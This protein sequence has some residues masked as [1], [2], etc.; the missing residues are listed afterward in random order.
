[1]QYVKFCRWLPITTGLLLG[2]VL[3]T[4][5]G[6]SHSGST[7]VVKESNSKLA[8]LSLST[9]VMSPAFSDTVTT[10]A[11]TIYSR[12]ASLQV[13]PTTGSSKAAVKVNGVTV[14]S[15]SGTSVALADGTNT[16]TILV[17]AEDGTTTTTTLTVNR[18]PATTP[19]YVLDSCNG[20]VVTGAT[21][22]VADDTGQTLESGIA[23]GS[24]GTTTLGLDTTKKYFLYSQATGAAQ[25][26]AA[27]FDPNANTRADFY[28]HDLGMISYPASAPVV[29]ALSYSADGTT[30]TPVTGNAITDVLANIRFLRVSA[31][32]TAG[33]SP[34]AWSGFGM[35]INVDRAAWSWDYTPAINEVENSTPVTYNGQ[36]RYRSTYDFAVSFTNANAATTHYIDLVI[37]DVANNRTEQKIPVTVTDAVTNTGDYDLSSATPTVNLVQ[38]S[39][40]ALTRDIFVVPSLDGGD[41]SYMTTVSFFVNAGGSYRGI[42]GFDL[43]RSSDGTNFTKVKTVNYPSLVT[44]SA[45]SVNDLDP[46]LAPGVT[47]TYKVKAFNANTTGNGGYSL[48]SNTRSSKFLAPFKTTL[49]APANGAVSTTTVPTFRFQISDPTLWDPAVSDYFYFYLYVKDKVGNEIYGHNFRY[50]FA[51]GTFQR[52]DSGTWPTDTTCSIS[53]DHTTI[54]I[55]FEDA[56]LLVPSE[57]YEWSIFGLSPYGDIAYGSRNASHFIKY[58]GGLTSQVGMSLGSTY[59]KSYGAVN[60][61]FT[62][63]IAPNAQ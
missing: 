26:C 22:T 13:T 7:T 20:S 28:C 31:I 63:T 59:E 48:E 8:G 40:Y 45:I 58:Y 9:G 37:Y 36:S 17:T 55:P 33:I 42:R 21:L 25:S 41:T 27:L 51:T 19:V 50:S 2:T 15:G 39:T 44:S 16:I 30:W 12:A 49:S 54:S 46:T 18:L 56:A 62:L 24:T 4:G 57:T 11:T 1:M 5:C 43:Y 3:S 34:T 53:D 61:Y 38:M 14:A 23:V 6:G 47:Y 52:Y 29:T 60:G 35:G 10:Y 32:G